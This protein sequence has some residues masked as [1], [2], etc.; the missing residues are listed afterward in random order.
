MQVKRDAACYCI[1]TAE[2]QHSGN[3]ISPVFIVSVQ[4]ET[5]IRARNICTKTRPAVYVV[6]HLQQPHYTV[7]H[8][9]IITFGEIQT[10]CSHRSDE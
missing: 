3:I 6:R 1:L 2:L 4:E 5:A 8:C 9:R 7:C 10:Q